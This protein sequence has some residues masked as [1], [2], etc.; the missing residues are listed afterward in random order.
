KYGRDPHF[1]KTIVPEFE[2]PENLSPIEM[3]GIIKK[4]GLQQNAITATIIRLGVMGYLKIEKIEAKVL[5]IN[6]SSFKLTRTDKKLGP[7][8]YLAES[9]ILGRVFIGVEKEVFLKDLGSNFQGEPNK[10][11]ELILVDLDKRG[12]VGKKGNELK[13]KMLILG[14]VFLGMG[15]FLS[16]IPGLFFSGLIILIF[17]LLMAKWTPEGAELNWRIKGFRL[18]METAEKYRSRWQEQTNQLEKFLPY[19]ILFGI[20]SQWL[21][22]MKDIYGEK[23][24]TNYHPA[25]MVGALAMS[26]FSD[27]TSAINQISSDINS[28]TAPSSTG[29]GGGGFSG[30]GGGGGGGGGW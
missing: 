16:I 3:G 10:I 2:I 30:G 15:L 8:L 27:F 19:A 4:G 26:N 28:Y 23:Y 21:K 12:L 9:Y 7:D 17:G 11:S 22:Q 5:F 24:L 25:F 29:A 13:I 18:Y 20:T 1:N 6:S 14:A